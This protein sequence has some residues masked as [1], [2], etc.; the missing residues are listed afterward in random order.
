MTLRQT[1][2]PL[3][4]AAADQQVR[5][6]GQVG[7]LVLAGNVLAQRKRQLARRI[8]KLVGRQALA[9]GDHLRDIVGHFDA[10]GGLAGNGRFDAHIDRR[11]RHREVVGQANDLLD[12]NARLQLHFVARDGRPHRDLRDVR[13][14]L[15]VVQRLHQDG[16]LFLRRLS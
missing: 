13:A 4:G 10:D 9:Q 11:Q 8:H 5:H 7:V 16:L 6:A 15:E 14:D 1:L 12:Q 2:L 3:I